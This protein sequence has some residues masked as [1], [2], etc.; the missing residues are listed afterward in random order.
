MCDYVIYLSITFI[1]HA[2]LQT[3]NHQLIIVDNSYKRIVFLL[4]HYYLSL[5]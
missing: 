5:L 1:Y 2:T 3:Y 4:A